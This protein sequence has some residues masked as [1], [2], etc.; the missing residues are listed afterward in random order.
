MEIAGKNARTR[1]S[2]PA[3]K[4]AM[5]ILALL[6]GLWGARSMGGEGAAWG[7]QGAHT[8]FYDDGTPRS[9]STLADGDLHGPART[10][11]RGGRL[12]SEGSYAHGERQG[13]WSFWDEDGN[14]DV[15]RSGLYADGERRA[16]LGE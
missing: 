11:H 14:L 7:A 13:P 12:A 16:P 4:V 9:E 3:M 5:L 15:G 6:G 2:K 10:W 8:T 1:P